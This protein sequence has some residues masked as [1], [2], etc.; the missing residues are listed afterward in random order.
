M[1]I[2]A[3]DY[4]EKRIGVAAGDTRTRVAVPLRVIEVRKD[5]AAAVARVLREEGA[6]EALVGLPV[7]LNGTHGPQVAQVEAFIRKLSGLSTVPVRSWDERLTTVEAE[8]RLRGA[9]K[10]TRVDALAAA[11]IL[12]AYLDTMPEAPSD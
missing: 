3:I 5:A 12:Q 1:R 11:I 10:G 2:I 6:A 8:S 9:P 7:S 4:G